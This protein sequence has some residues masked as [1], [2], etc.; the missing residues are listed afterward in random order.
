MF[1]QEGDL[2]GI[3]TV[4]VASEQAPSP[5]KLCFGGKVSS[6]VTTCVGLL[7]CWFAGLVIFK[8]RFD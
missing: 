3:R 2:K 1:P 8:T 6:K 5:Q 7:V 4:F